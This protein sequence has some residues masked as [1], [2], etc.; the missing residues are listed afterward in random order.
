MVG[1]RKGIDI[2]ADGGYVV[3]P[4]SSIDGKPNEFKDIDKEIAELPLWVFELLT[5]LFANG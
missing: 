1:F 2:R 5:N 4:G 3:A